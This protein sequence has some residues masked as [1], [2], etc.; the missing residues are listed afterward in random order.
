MKLKYVLVSTV[1]NKMTADSETVI[2]TKPGTYFGD[3]TNTG[4]GT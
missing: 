3:N 2:I 4:S 1:L